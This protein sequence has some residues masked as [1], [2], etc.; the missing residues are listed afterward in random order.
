[1]SRRAAFSAAQQPADTVAMIPVARNKKARSWEKSNRARAYYIP[2]HLEEKAI[3]IRDE[4][5]GIAEGINVSAVGYTATDV[6][7]A[8]MERALFKVEKGVIVLD[9][10]ADPAY[11]KT[12]LI[13]VEVEG[14]SIPQS[15]VRKEKD[16]TKKQTF[17]AYRWQVEFDKRIKSLS[18]QNHIA[19]GEIVVV[20]LSKALNAYKNGD[21]KL[22]PQPST[23][24]QT[25]T[26]AWK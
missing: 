26:G 14:K 17:L 15:I 12:N 16:E 9:A 3:A 24:K 4:I 25:V 10:R 19:P 21:L 7:V 11:R 13:C 22:I 1:M 8:F 18:K 2:R 20:L 23:V 5:V 6:A